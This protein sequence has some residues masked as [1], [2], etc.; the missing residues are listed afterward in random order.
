MAM[1]LQ[2]GGSQSLDFRVE[3]GKENEEDA[4]TINFCEGR[5]DF[6]TIGIS[7]LGFIS[8]LTH[9]GKFSSIFY[10]LIDEFDV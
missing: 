8:F 2:G 7:P 10:S 9:Q 1:E 4:S 3:L 5:L 6:F